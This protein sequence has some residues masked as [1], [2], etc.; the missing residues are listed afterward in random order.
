[1]SIEL[2]K[3][4]QSVVDS[5]GGELLV[6]AAAGSGKTRVL[7]ERLLRRVEQ[8]GLDLDQFLVITF[9]KAAAAELRSKIL[10]EVNRRL[11]EDPD[12]SHLRRQTTFI[13][14]AQISTIHAFCTAFLRENSHLLDLD[15]DFRVADEE[16]AELLRTQTLDRLL[17][18]RY[19]A[20]EENGFAAL[21]DSL[22]AGRDDQRLVDITLDVHRRIQAHPDPQGWLD[23]QSAALRWVPGTDPAE[24]PWGKL[25]MADAL[26]QVRYWTSQIDQALRMLE[27]DDA[28]YR[29]Y[30]D[31]FVA[32]LDALRDLSAALE[33]GMS[34]QKGWDEA[35]ACV[36]IPFPTLGRSTKITDKLSQE[37]A[38]AIRERCKKAMGKLAVRFES[39]AESLMADL[40][41]VAPVVEQ[42]FDLV[43][44]LERDF[45]AAKQ[46]RKLLDFNDL[47][48]M[49]VRALV[50]DGAPTE[51][52][53]Q[54][55][56]RYAE[57]MVDEY[58][59]TN[60]VQNAIFDA[61][62]EQG[63][64]LFQVGDVKQSIYRF[65]LADPTIFL[66]K[67]HSFAPEA[68]AR[69]G[70]PRLLV[71][72]RNFRSRKGVLDAVNF[73][74]S[75][76][77]TRSFGEIDYT[78]DQRLNPGR[79]DAQQEEST[80]ELDVVDL[81]TL[82]REEQEAAIPKDLAEARYV[83]QRVRALLDEGLTVPEG[84][85][86]RPLRPEDIA[87][88]YRSPGSVLH[89]L[90]AALDEQDVPWQNEGF[91]DFFQTTEV[92]VALSFLEVLDNPREDVPLLSV[93]RCPV[94]GFT[95]D[96]LAALRGASRDTD[97]FGCVEKGALAG[98]EHCIHFL[99]DLKK[100]RLRLLDSGCAQLL[101]TLYNELGLLAL[102]GAMSGGERRQE[103]LLAFYDF[104]R[105]FEETGHRGV[106]P[107][108]TQLRRLLER[109]KSPGNVRAAV[110][111]GV[112]IMSIHKSKG[113]EFPV[114]VLAGLNRQFNRSDERLPM[115]FHSKLGVGPKLLDE[116][117]RL[118]VPTLARTAVQLQLEK[119][120]RAEE[121]RLLYV[122][123]TRAKER[124]ILIMSSRDADKDLKKLLPDAA[125]QPEPEALAALDSVGKWLLL[126]VLCRRDAAALW[127]EGAP[128]TLTQ[129]EDRWDIRL[130]RADQD[131][132]APQ[133]REQSPTAQKEVHET[134]DGPLLEAL[135][136]SYPWQSLADLPSK[137]TATQ[138][139]GRRLDEEAAEETSRPAL[140]LEFRRPS[141][142]QRRRGLT[143]AQA[144][145]AV[146]AVMEHIDIDRAD[147]ISGVKAEL[148][149]LVSARYLTPEQAQAVDAA[150][151]ARFW[152]SPLGQEAVNSGSL[153]REFKFS[154]LA[155]ASHFYAG[156]DREEE[157]LVQG[158]V[159]CCFE[160]LFG[161]TVVDFKSDRV[162]RGGEAQR[163]E[164]YRGQVE[165]YARALEEIF[166]KPVVRRVVWFLRTGK[167]VEV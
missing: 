161:F 53:R 40:A 97:L 79:S 63:Q 48:H 149:R 110:G 109:G 157:V 163:A 41:A 22:S 91:E 132:F 78:E 24:T 136:W 111:S 154:I 156:A 59:D 153:R 70:A 84:T 68:L 57:V 83:A 38:K 28:L 5:R 135:Q 131:C 137:V 74:F 6:S 124:L 119:E 114:V 121:L 72:S 66:H 51:L 69:P 90:T 26:S 13:Y 29:A 52:A 55:A 82:E 167:G 44:E 73:V 100:L 145:S 76:L 104:A 122:A 126:P 8:E 32:T 165:V 158:V 164:E 142:E 35:R 49:T 86:K 150:Q 138:M 102:F 159:D 11:A 87:I 36:N 80:T 117:L 21:V 125:P 123:M 9:T 85:E 166:Q 62:T 2:T 94:Y 105:S 115:L 4:Q 39:D 75:A 47:E 162:R 10:A 120:R 130:I 140:T 20:M 141:F 17:E 34:S 99:A 160:T 43:G 113:L 18:R 134:E 127:T 128:D 101:W 67:Y 37:R 31:S 25:L 152:A 46:R 50:R 118:E 95:A 133:P 92:S 89:Y 112:Q 143:P 129:P 147:T 106:F 14:R 1:M 93:L 155:G 61:L 7:V 151:V 144:G 16:E 33:G 54:W 96:Q 77:M 116:E 12:Q 27:G 56:Q 19:E 107:F 148:E 65:R 42:L 146:H 108:V 30:S 81:S 15:P 3:E 23:R 45:L 64:R 71:L 103:N 139:K 58:Q 60:E 98:E 88:L